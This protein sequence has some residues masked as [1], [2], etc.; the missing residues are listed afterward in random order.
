MS[1]DK[2]CFALKWKS[3]LNLFK[4]PEGSDATTQLFIVIRIRIAIARA[5]ME[6]VGVVCAIAGTFSGHLDLLLFIH[7]FVEQIQLK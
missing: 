7:A 4:R 6:V 3:R 5:V 1:K 2:F